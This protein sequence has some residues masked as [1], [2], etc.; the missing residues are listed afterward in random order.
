MT[1]TSKLLL[2]AVFSLAALP[3]ASAK[4]TALYDCTVTQKKKGV[5]WISN[6]VG[7]VLYND[8]TA[9]VSDSV[10]LQ[11]NNAPMRAQSVSETNK[12]IKLR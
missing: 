9:M 2:A 12:R 8:G 11:F 7:I 4:P 3:V 10:I 5:G 1:I 6:K